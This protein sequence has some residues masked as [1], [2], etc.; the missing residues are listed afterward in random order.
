MPRSGADLDD[1]SVCGQE[2]R[3]DRE[4]IQDIGAGSLRSGISGS[5]YDN[6]EKQQRHNRAYNGSG[7]M[8]DEHNRYSDRVRILHRSDSGGGILSGATVL[9]SKLENIVTAPK[10]GY[11]G[12]LGIDIII[13]K[14]IDI[15]VKTFGNMENIVY[16]VKE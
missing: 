1:E 15:D 14:R 8:D 3:K 11:D 7:D 2:V 13:N 10:S 6:T 4:Y 9:L 16:A 12:H 5:R